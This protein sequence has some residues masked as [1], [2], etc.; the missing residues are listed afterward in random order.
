[1]YIPNVEDITHK[2]RYAIVNGKTI[3]TEAPAQVKQGK[4]YVPVKF[5]SQ[6]VGAK[7]V[8]DYKTR[9]VHITAEGVVAP[10]VPPVMPRDEKAELAT[11]KY[12]AIAIKAKP[13]SD[14]PMQPITNYTTIDKVPRGNRM[15]VVEQWYDKFSIIEQSQLPLRQ[16]ELNSILAI[17]TEILS[18][19]MGVLVI[20]REVGNRNQTGD[21]IYATKKEG[22]MT[23]SNM[24]IEG[25]TE[26]VAAMNLNGHR[27]Y[28][29]KN[30]Y[31]LPYKEYLG[32]TAKDIEG[33]VFGGVPEKSAI[34]VKI[35]L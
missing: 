28:V 19:G 22:F 9:H 30:R 11:A 12:E 13:F 8:F 21:F 31:Y 2:K 29:I 5:V 25:L 27:T 10:S 20:T 32:I 1:M 33:I 35:K 24:P 4:T 26:T 14:F 17:D 7:A 18:N 16:D 3:D 6:T 34:M 15:G 23:R